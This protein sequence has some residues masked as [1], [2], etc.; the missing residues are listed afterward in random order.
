MLHELAGEMI[1]MGKSDSPFAAV[2]RTCL[3]VNRLAKF[4][5]AD[6]MLHLADTE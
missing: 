6:E 2:A 1:A 4:V 5:V 3:I